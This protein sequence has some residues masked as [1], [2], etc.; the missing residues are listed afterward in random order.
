MVHRPVTSELY[1]DLVEARNDERLAVRG[2]Q[3]PPDTAW[4]QERITV[5]AVAKK[6]YI[7]RWFN[8]SHAQVR[9]SR[10]M[11]Y[12]LDDRGKDDNA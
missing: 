10:D 3:A 6:K 4:Y 7:I 8:I 2:G 12:A 1:P 9:R 5:A 11:R